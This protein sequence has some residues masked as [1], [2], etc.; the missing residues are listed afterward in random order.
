[1]EYL[2]NAVLGSFSSGTS[3]TKDRDRNI[4]QLIRDQG[5]PFEMHFY[6][7]E[8]GYIN[9]VV[10]IS[11]GKN[12][13]PIK[14]LEKGGPRK[15]VVILQHGL[16]CSCTDWIL[17]DKNSLAFI[18]A[19]NGYDVWMNNTRGNRYSRHHMFLDPDVDK[20]EFWD[21]SFE[22]MAKYDQPALFNFVLMKTGVAK[23]TYIGHSQGTSQMFCA[24]SENLQFFKDRMNLFIAL[25]PVVRLDSC[26][27]GLIL[28][29]KDNQHIENLLIKNEIFEITPAKKNNKAAAFFHKIFPEISNF[30]LKMLSDDDPREVNQ[31]CLE[32]YLSHYPAGTSLKTIRHFKQVMNK[33]SFEHF[34]YGQEENIRRYGQEQP[35][36]IPLENIK[37]FPIALLAGQE[38]KLANIN[39]VRWLKE[40]LESQNSVVFYEEYKFGH[41]SFLIPNSLKH[42]QDVVQLV[43]KYN[44][45]YLSSKLRNYSSSSRSGSFQNNYQMESGPNTPQKEQAQLI[46]MVENLSA[47]QSSSPLKEDSQLNNQGNDSNKIDSVQFM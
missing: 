17:N 42:F 34:D 41:L 2:S 32:G 7:T 19:D 18:L 30:G 21:Y 46:Q 23:V 15:P 10:R 14:N 20:K 27:S 22:D 12:S 47:T 6:E 16:N 31:N 3:T 11:G 43:N 9:K 35:P 33:K 1:M 28:K 24:L 40:K 37:D 26:S 25:A 13:D 4:Y 38:D 8:D 45:V 39:D 44:P 29:M 36:Q 5:Y